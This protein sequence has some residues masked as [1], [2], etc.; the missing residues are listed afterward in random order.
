[1]RVSEFLKRSVNKMEEIFGIRPF[2]IG[3]CCRIRRSG[4]PYFMRISALCRCRKVW[5]QRGGYIS[6]EEPFI[7][8]SPVMREKLELCKQLASSDI[9]VLIVG[10]NGVGKASVARQLHIHSRR[11]AYPFIR[12][13]CAEPAEELLAHR[14][15]GGEDGSTA[16]EDCFK[17]AG[18]GTL[19]LDEA[20]VLPLHLQ[21]KLLD[22]ILALEQSGGNI[23]LIAS[24]ARDLERLTREGTFYRNCT[25]G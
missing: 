13:N 20:A 15:F 17:Q 8:A 1:M 19:F 14:L 25:V 12:V 2:I 7:A 11:A 5:R 10:E 16:G 23:R 22:R 3:Y 6:K 24:T 18:G 4:L 9:P 21:K